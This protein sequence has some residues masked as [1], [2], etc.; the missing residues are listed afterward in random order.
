[1]FGKYLAGRRT[2]DEGA[3]SLVCGHVSMFFVSREK[4]SALLC[5]NCE[6]ERCLGILRR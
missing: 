3:E 1:M 4:L 6:L 5:S 2:L